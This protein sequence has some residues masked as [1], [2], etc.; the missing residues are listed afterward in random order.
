MQKH[1]CEVS[2]IEFETKDMSSSDA[3][4]TVCKNTERLKVPGGWLY[5]VSNYD[6]RV[7]QVCFVPEPDRCV[8][9]TYETLYRV[10]GMCEL[11][12]KNNLLER[13]DLP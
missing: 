10:C 8:L 6:K 4:E 2:G 9:H 1:V 5:N 13:T 12:K 11:E 7:E 3:W